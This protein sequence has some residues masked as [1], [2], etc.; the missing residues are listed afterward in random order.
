LNRTLT[1]TCVL[2]QLLNGTFP[3]W[4]FDEVNVTELSS[5]SCFDPDQC[6]DIPEGSEELTNNF[7]N[8][9]NNTG[10]SFQYFCNLGKKGKTNSS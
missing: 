9:N 7:D 2:N 8:L 4:K 1:A 3:F 10:D 5:L 6:R